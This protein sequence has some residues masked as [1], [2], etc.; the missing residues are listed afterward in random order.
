MT[1][2]TIGFLLSYHYFKSQDMDELAPHFA[3]FPL[4]LDSGAFSALTL[5]K[6]INIEEY[7]TFIKRYG[8][9]FTTI[10]N[11]DVINDPAASYTNW[12]RLKELGAETVPVVH[13]GTPYTYLDKYIEAGERY[14]LVG[15][16][17][18]RSQ[19]TEVR[20]WLVGVFR[21]GEPHGV[22]FHGFGLTNM[23]DLADFPWYSC[24]SSTWSAAWRFGNVHLW[25]SRGKRVSMQVGN[26]K[27]VYK[28]ARLLR[29]HGVEPALLADRTKYHYLHALTASVIAW[30]R[31]GR[32]WH[33]RHKPVTAGEGRPTGP[34]LYLADTSRTHLIP[35]AEAI[36][37]Y[38]ALQGGST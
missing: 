3:G 36:R 17:V 26:P 20:A 21:R 27:S 30:Y 18:G 25:D 37:A 2:R 11:L 9:H 23:Q 34:I 32:W 8:H 28:H 31:L 12:L 14:I 13:Y 24:D 22:G 38:E 6:P 15:G 5:G 33:E 4:F 35:G 19:T 1:D 7:A 10:A 29:E 16:L